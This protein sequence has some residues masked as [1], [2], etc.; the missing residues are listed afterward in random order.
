MLKV[1][2]C[3]FA[4]MGDA[5]NIVPDSCTN[6]RLW[7]VPVAVADPELVTSSEVRAVSKFPHTESKTPEGA[8]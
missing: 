4:W 6:A 3:R 8:K 7:G 1:R 5:C 2:L